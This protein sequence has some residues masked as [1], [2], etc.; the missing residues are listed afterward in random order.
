MGKFDYHCAM[1]LDHKI[2]ILFS[3]TRHTLTP[4]QLPQTLMP[5]IRKPTSTAVIELK[6]TTCIE[7]IWKERCANDVTIVA[8]NTN[9]D[10]LAFFVVSS[11]TQ[12]E[13]T[14]TVTNSVFSSIK[15]VKA[16]KTRCH[17]PEA[18]WKRG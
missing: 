6:W 8:C 2:T 4:P 15:L 7:W 16:A 17:F 9:N 18:C 12:L 11:T 1:M 13:Y 10:D 3:F 14:F 5:A